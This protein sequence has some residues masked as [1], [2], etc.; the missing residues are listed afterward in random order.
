MK[1]KKRG[2]KATWKTQKIMFTEE[3][4]KKAF[5]KATSEKQETLIM[6][7]KLGALTKIPST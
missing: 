5:I 3:N 7:K 2:N 4:F 6:K 1:K